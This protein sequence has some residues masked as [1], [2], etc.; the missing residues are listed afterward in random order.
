[1]SE[2]DWIQIESGTAWLGDERG[3]LMHA[4]NGP[5]HEIRIESR[6]EISAS[7]ITFTQ[8]K[9]LTGQAVAG[10]SS[11]DPVNRLTPLMIEAGLIGVEGN[12]RPPSEAEWALATKQGA[13]GPGDV[14]VE[15]L[16]DRPPRSG[17]W[18]APCNG[19]PW[20]HS[21]R[22]GGVSDHSAH[23]TRVWRGSGTMRGATPRGV[24][25]PQMGFRLVRS[26]TPESELNMPNSPSQKDLLIRESTFA[27]LIGILPSF[28]WAYFNASERYLSESWLNIAVGGI[29][30]SLMTA[31][32]WRPKTP[33]YSIQDGKVCRD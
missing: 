18:G 17:Y 21:V 8:W 3:A 27:L 30:F 28:T 25:R 23:T 29:F 20:I 26:T 10:E 4:G 32:L 6:F 31:F 2:I 11:E 12:P 16:S 19:Q 24:S 9:E 1:V 5:R 7:P 33:S 14:Q 15:V 22:A 13:I